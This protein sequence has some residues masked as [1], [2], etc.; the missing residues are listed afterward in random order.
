MHDDRVEVVEREEAVPADGGVLRADGFQRAAAQVAGE[1]D[2][3]DVLRRQRPLRRDRLD[4]AHRSLER[5]VLVDPELFDELA[6]QRIHEALA[7]V[8]AA[9]AQQPVLLARLLVATEEDL[10]APAEERRDADARLARHVLDPKP[11]SPR[12]L[13]G[14][15]STTSC[16][17]RIPG[18]TSKARSRS[19]LSRMTRSSP[20]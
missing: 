17:I 7:A 20:R 8:D 9:A 11:R 18:S 4:D 1:H 2:V 12:S 3:H 5:N 14:S 13:S 16:A 15:S 10:A 6:V 19:V